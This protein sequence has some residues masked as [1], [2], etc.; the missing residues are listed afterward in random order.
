MSWGPCSDWTNEEYMS[1]CRQIL[2]ATGVSLSHT[3]L[4]RICGK[5]RYDNSPSMTTLNALAVFVG[6]EH[7]RELM[8]AVSNGKPVAKRFRFSR[9]TGWIAAATVAFGL[10]LSFTIIKSGELPGNIS[11][12]V[13]FTSR[14]VTTTYPNSVVFDLD[15]AGISSDDMRIQQYWDPTKTISLSP[16]QTAAT[17][18]YYLPGY[19]RAS[20]IVDETVV[21]GH[22]L[23][24]KSDGWIATIGGDSIPNYISEEV[25]IDGKIT[26]SDSIVN[27]IADRSKPTSLTYHYVAETG[28][29]ADNFQLTTTFRNTL[30]SGPSVCKS[31]RLLVLCTKSAIIVPVSIPGCISNN[32]LMVSDQY[33]SG[34]END[35]SAFSSN[36]T[37][38]Q[39]LRLSN[40][41]QTLT[42]FLNDE[43]V[44]QVPY[45]DSLGKIAGFR[46]AFLGAG[47]ILSLEVNDGGELSF[48]AGF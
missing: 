15:L 12:Q 39:H 48:N 27:I 1:A 42:V 37:G 2:E 20:L 19:Y 5:V 18:I 24:L 3:T 21:K 35:L 31:L 8:N 44:K 6:Y 23:F 34:K 17:G 28:I 38:P 29:D 46:F 30:A 43:E 14:P 26:V 9:R 40:R 10:V 41:N 16:G 25:A 45:N 13:V 7:W 32:N 36:M 33:F 4:K 11:D 22:D 47:E